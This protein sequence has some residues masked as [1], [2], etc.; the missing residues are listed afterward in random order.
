MVLIVGIAG[1]SCSGKT[2]LTLKLQTLLKDSGISSTVLSQDRYYNKGLPTDNFDSP[3]S[4]NWSRLIQDLTDLKNGK[5]IHAPLYD[6]ITH[7]PKPETELIEPA[8]VILVEGILLFSFI[9]I[10]SIFDFKIFV[11]AD[12]YLRFYR[13]IKRDVESRGRTETEVLTQYCH[14]VMPSYKKYIKPSKKYA[15]MTIFNNDINLGDKYK[16]VGIDI[17]YN[18]IVIMSKAQHI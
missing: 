7:S 2:Y 3:K 13:R 18:Q 6:F 12:S 17:L 1:A 11:E 4:L 10:R 5:S 8:K 9:D 14:Q 16:F 15:D